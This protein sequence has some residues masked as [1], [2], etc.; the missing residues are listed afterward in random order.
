MS[1]LI[2]NRQAVS[3]GSQTPSPG[4]NG[5]ATSTPDM[6]MM[7][8][9]SITHL[10]PTMSTA[11]V[12]STSSVTHPVLSAKWTCGQPRSSKEAQ[13]FGEASSVTL[14]VGCPIK[15]VDR[16]SAAIFNTRN[17]WG[18]K[19]PEIYMFKEVYAWSGDELTDPPWCRRARPFWRRWLPSFPKRPR[20][21][22]C[23]PPE[24][25]RFQIMTDTLDQ[26][27]G[28]RHRN[29]HWGLGKACLRD[30]STSSSRQ[31]TEEVKML[32]LKWRT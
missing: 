5:T 19:F 22:R 4:G 6:G 14:V 30:P 23:Y 31:R 7:G 2:S 13:P 3:R 1:N 29:V 24:D 10:G 17:T 21:K 32:N 9:P 16:C 26:T 25:A 12:S 11:P 27:L 15:L 18:S 8:V 28:H 20:S